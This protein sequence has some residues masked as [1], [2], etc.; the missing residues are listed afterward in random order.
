MKN[1]HLLYVEDDAHARQDLSA[2][3]EAKGF[4]LSLAASGSEGLGQFQ[5]A[6]ADVILCDLHMPEMDGLEVLRQVKRINAETPVIILTARGSV[7]QAV[8]AIKQGANDFVLKPVEINTIET[9]IQKALEQASL[10]QALT[11]SESNLQMLLETVPDLVYSL[12][13]KGRFLSVSPAGERLLGYAI[14]EMLGR[15]VFDYVH[16]HDREQLKASFQKTKT[17]G[18]SKIKTLQFRMICKSGKTRHFEVNRRLI[19]ENGKVV[20]Q[21]G[22]ARDIT[23]RKELEQELRKKTRE[24]E[25]NTYSLARANIELLSV[26]EQLEHKNKEMERLLRKVSETNNRLQAILDS[27]LSAIVMVDLNNRIIA[28]NRRVK[29]FFCIDTTA[30]MN[31][32]ISRFNN[33]IK[34]CFK[35]QKKFQR[36]AERLLAHPDTDI[37]GLSDME[38]IYERAFELST[39]N[40]RFVSVFAIP[41]LDKDN[42][43]LGSVWIYNDI[44]KMKRADEQLRAIME[45]S[46]FP[47]I[48][49]RK[50]DGKILYANHQ[51]ADLIG[52]KRKALTGAS[53]PDYYA[54]PEERKIVLEKV[55]QNGS[56]R[57]HEVE[58]RK[59][60]GTT[61]WMIFS[62]ETTEIG[63]ESV[64]ISSLYDISE[65]KK[66]EE[67]LRESEEKFR[68]LNENIKE[69][70]WMVDLE[71]HEMIYVSPSYE[72]IFGRPRELL[73]KNPDNWLN[74]VHPD[75]IKKL[76]SDLEQAGRRENE[77]E[78]RIIRPDNSVRWIRSRAFAVRNADGEI[79]RYCGVSEDITERKLA[80]EKLHLYKEIFQNSNDPITILDPDGFFLEQNPAA[81][82]LYRY[83]DEELR[84]KTPALF[85]SEETF[86]KIGE[87][88]TRTG[89]FR[90]EIV[91]HPKNGA[92]VDVELSAFSMYDDKG[93]VTCRIGFARDITERKQAEKALQESLRE[94]ARANQ[95]LHQTQGQLV[96][97]EKM[98]SLGMLVAGIAHEINTP[99]G[100]VHSMHD[101]LKRAVVRLEQTLETKYAEDLKNDGDL[102][103]PLRIIQDANKVIDTGSERVTTIV[104][105][106]R[107]FARLDEAELK[108]VDIHEGLEDTL[109]LIHHEIKHN[110]TV[111]KN[112]G[113]IPP[114]PCFPGRLNQ[115]FLNLLINAKQAIRERGTITIT[116]RLVHPK[117]QIRMSDDGA[118]I[119]QEKLDKVFDP[120]FTTK[121]VG[122]G[123]G[124][125]LSICYQIIQDHKGKITVESEV[126]KG[127]TFTIMLPMNLDKLLEHEHVDRSRPAPR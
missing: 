15:S 106:L 65:R 111:D 126:G 24:S 69:V 26:Q 91:S 40:I 94:L 86:S 43:E 104:R 25:K 11:R 81:R 19:F 89:S 82:K 73:Y 113:D 6:G 84:G 88:L 101:T 20:R 28:S 10:E 54:N 45:A 46:P 67:A 68:Q 115:V 29:D 51:M 72:D 66:A 53:A 108:L 98:A 44:T 120:G 35:A 96:Q 127:T 42:K 85:T 3:L 18:D 55:N 99:I 109:T 119:P 58:I 27:S 39:P 64:F 112:Y 5:S 56:L 47:V 30:M 78:F 62:I 2:K 60:D 74:A 83:T 121:G 8:S 59:A 31:Q 9:T 95:H 117:V 38:K 90:G 52:V 93:E 71:L 49:T 48:V 7:E 37:E 103:G 33:G 100:A 22:I 76:S 105:R 114:I 122:V 79:Y 1:I 77:Q 123:T 34:S 23:K 118:G 102:Y 14:S 16:P 125:G 70:F 87:S 116:T 92:P 4:R 124:L 63:G 107:S 97:S 13:S 17:A 57:N 32:P 41:V 21:D 50:Q 110:I 36:L 75:D 61:A 12:N 80:Q